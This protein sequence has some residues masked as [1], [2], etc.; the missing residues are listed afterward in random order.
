MTDRTEAKISALSRIDRAAVDRVVLH[1]RAGL[2]VLAGE[3]PIRRRRLWH[4][5]PTARGALGGLLALALVGALA[6]TFRPWSGD[7]A[8]AAL[9]QRVS[10]AVTPPPH[11]IQ[12]IVTVLHQGTLV[13]TTES[14][15]SID[16]PYTLRWRQ[17]SSTTCGGEWT[18]E[19]SSTLGQKQ[20]LD[21]DHGLVLRIPLVP[22]KERAAVPAGGARGQFDPTVSFASALGHGDAHVAGRTTIDGSA[23]TRISWP[24]VDVNDPASRNVIYV[25]TAT[26]VP[27]AYQWGGGKLDATGGVVARQTFPTYEFLPEDASSRR[28]LSVSQSH[29]DAAMPPITTERQL[30]A[31]YQ[32][33][34]RRHCGG[35][36]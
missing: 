7:H 17:T 29:P 18:T 12:H 35:V 2:G 30:S 16:D 3:R 32:D 4:A 20:W 5:P 21:S 19:M 1:A 14:W 25:A 22:A 15:Q 26:G 36:G 31:S 27:V 10:I 28:A 13:M 34:Q 11:T 33:A 24:T 6:F 23:V 8:D 9:L